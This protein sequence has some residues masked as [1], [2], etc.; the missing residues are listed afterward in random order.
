MR[1]ASP[2]S[3]SPTCPH[4]AAARPTPTSRGPR[5]SP[6][7]GA[8]CWQATRAVAGSRRTP[9]G[10]RGWRWACAADRSGGCRCSPCASGCSPGYRQGAAGARAVHRRGR[11]RGAHRLLRRPPRHPPLRPGRLRPAPHAV[12]RRHPAAR[13]PAR[14]RR[15]PRGRRRPRPDRG[16]GHAHPGRR[17]RRGPGHRAGG[18]RPADRRRR[19]PPRLRA[20]APVQPVYPRRRRRAHRRRP[21]RPRPARARRPRP[22]ELARRGQPI[23]WP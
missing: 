21:A 19:P 1:S 14:N 2:R 18:R 6:G 5:R 11:G 23:V 8:G 16:R 7:A 9:R 20:A 4:A 17:A 10:S 3:P 15:H 13:P 12:R 22:R